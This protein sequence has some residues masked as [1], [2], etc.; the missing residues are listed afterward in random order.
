VEVFPE[1]IGPRISSKYPFFLDLFDETDA[2]DAVGVVVNIA[3]VGSDN[4]KGKGK[5]EG[6]GGGDGK[7]DGGGGDGV[8]VH[9][10]TPDSDKEF[11]V[12]LV[13]LLPIM[14]AFVI[15]IIIYISSIIFIVK[16]LIK[17]INL[18]KINNNILLC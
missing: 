7:R 6:E 9:D 18:Y 1:N 17:N 16:K 5:G 11:I 15:L 10:T 3:L 4:G 8:G 13:V 2:V 14:F 12:M